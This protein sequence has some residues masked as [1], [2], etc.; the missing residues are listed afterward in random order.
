VK[1]N[2][3]TPTP[4]SGATYIISNV[5]EDKTVVV[6]YII[7]TT[8]FF[9]I[10]LTDS[11]QGTTTPDVTS[12]NYGEDIELSFAPVDGWKVSTVKINGGTPTPVS[13]ATYI[14]SNVTEDKTVVVEYII[15]TTQTHTMS[16][17]HIGMGSITFVPT[18]VS[19][20]SSSVVTVTPDKGWTV[21]LVLDNG[22]PVAVP[23]MGGS[24]TLSDIYQDHVVIATFVK[25]IP[26]VNTYVII[27][28]AGAGGTMDPIG[29][30]KVSGGSSQT[31]RF[32][33][34]SG[35]KVSMV[36]IDGIERP[37]LI[38]NE[39]YTF[40]NIMA[41][42]TI[43]VYFA[44]SDM[45]SLEVEV[46]G[47]GLVEYSIDGV[48][49]LTY[50]GT[51]FFE[52]G[53]DVKLR[54]FAGDNYRFVAWDNGSSRSINPEIEFNDVRASV[55]IVADFEENDEGFNWWIPAIIAAI[56]GSLIIALLYRKSRDREVY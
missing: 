10:F 15:D 54:A 13:G 22:I 31:F 55:F 45:V 18:L 49:F 30:I 44:P 42:K 12:V 2:G 17:T 16:E 11:G 56:I 34:D 32:I 38:S 36:K 1:I 3:G 19:G 27:S 48:T 51:V 52:K 4:V 20:G 23:A 53:T 28:T 5:T 7:D 24:F 47:N 14:I 6:E 40:V 8:V 46:Q 39:S 33:P 50:V 9:S 41:S 25:H 35:Y 37:D 26:P 21:S 29:T 43:E